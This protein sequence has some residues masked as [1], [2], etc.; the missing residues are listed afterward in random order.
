MPLQCNLGMKLELGYSRY[1]PGAARRGRDKACAALSPT[2]L[3]CL[4]GPSHLAFHAL[5]PL[6]PLSLAPLPP[7]EKSRRQ[8]GWMYLGSAL[9]SPQQAAPARQITP[10][11][12]C[13]RRQVSAAGTHTQAVFLGAWTR[14]KETRAHDCQPL[15]KSWRARASR[16]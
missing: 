15:N 12:A 8:H 9:A 11:S 2:R 5:K 10:P 16:P 4:S 7:K 3:S 6:P 1:S 14:R 13:H